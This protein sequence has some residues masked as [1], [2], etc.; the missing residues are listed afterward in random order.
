MFY[1]KQTEL[2]QISIILNLNNIIGAI[3]MITSNFTFHLKY[4]IQ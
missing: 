3:H 1:F 4:Q 2:N